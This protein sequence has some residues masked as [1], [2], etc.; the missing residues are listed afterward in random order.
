VSRRSKA[1]AAVFAER[2]YRYYIAVK[3]KEKTAEETLR[4]AVLALGAF[5]RTLLKTITFDNGLENAP[6]GRIDAALGTAS[7]FCKP[8]H[9]WEPDTKYP[10]GA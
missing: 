8:Y 5:P 2:K 6:R 9:R 4:A 7:Y 1:A 3:L 10:W